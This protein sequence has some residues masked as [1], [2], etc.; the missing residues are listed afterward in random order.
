MGEFHCH[1]PEFRFGPMTGA[2]LIEV[3]VFPAFP[4][5]T[6]MTDGASGQ[7]IP[8]GNMLWNLSGTAPPASAEFQTNFQ[9]LFGERTDSRVWNPNPTDPQGRSA[10][11]PA[12]RG[13][14][15][16]SPRGQRDRQPALQNPRARDPAQ[17]RPRNSDRAPARPSRTLVPTT[18]FSV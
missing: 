1:I 7:A 6:Q 13:R 5:D 18:P 14:N 2:P 15:E 17:D 8:S 11:T 4:E 12:Q 3:P 9:Q 10:I 16:F